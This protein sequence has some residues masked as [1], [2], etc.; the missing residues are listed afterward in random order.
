MYKIF[1]VVLVVVVFILT[2]AYSCTNAM[3]NQYVAVSRVGMCLVL[4]HSYCQ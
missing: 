4:E 1:V 3:N 2:D